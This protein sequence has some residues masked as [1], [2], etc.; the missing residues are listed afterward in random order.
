MNP[1]SAETC[2]LMS[3]ASGGCFGTGVKVAETRV[4]ALPVLLTRARYATLP[5]AFSFKAH[6]TV[7]RRRDTLV[8]RQTLVLLPANSSI[9]HF[10]VN[11]KV[12][13]FM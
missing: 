3:A 7:P 6:V 2:F 9:P 8:A 5:A 11:R 13:I 12:S 10:Q 4:L 1:I